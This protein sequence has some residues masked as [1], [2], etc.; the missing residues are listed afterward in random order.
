MERLGIRFGSFFHLAEIFFEPCAIETG[1]IQ[2]LRG[3]HKCA[4]LAA[5]GGAKRAEVAA[6]FWREK[7]E[8]LLRVF[9]HRHYDSFLADLFVPGF[10]TCKPVV[11]RRVG[12]AAEKRDDQQIADGLAFG[13]IRVNPEAVAGL[14][15]RHVGNWQRLAGAR[16]GHLDARACQIESGGIGAGGSG[17][18]RQQR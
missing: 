1:L 4:G 12:G 17:C 6:G 10:G 9:R 7:N 18:D 3:A 8:R 11:G 5:H 16:D 15:V 13:K 2:I 14:E